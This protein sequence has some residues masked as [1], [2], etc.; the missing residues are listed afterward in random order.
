MS[1]P[2]I[3][4][5]GLGIMGDAMAQALLAG[6]HRVT[7][8]DV[9]AEAKK[10][11]K[12]AGGRLLA[13]AAA[14]GDASDIVIVSLATSKALAATVESLATCKPR[15]DTRAL[16]VLETSTLPL[17]DKNAALAALRKVGI[18]V[19]DCP[20]S[21]TGVRMKERAWTFFCSGA[22]AGYQR[23]EATLRVFTDKI[24]YVGA[25]GNGTKMKYAANHLVAIYNVAYGESVALARKMGLDPQD[26][27]DL[28]ANSPVLGTGV[29]RLRMPFMV[30]RQYT[31]PTMKVEVWQKDMQ[32]I[33]DMAKSVDCPTPLFTAC[34]SIY[35]AAMAQGLDQHDTASV[36][37]V[38]ASMAGIPP[39]NAP[40][41]VVKSAAKKAGKPK[42]A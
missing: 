4:I 22:K 13:S 20:I 29:M 42:K 10:R 18:Q 12:A 2:V 15:A 38:Y 8:Y 41:G 19:L 9:S 40:K 11:F 16:V 23:V 28:F 6:G 26:V 25:F 39:K 21:G 7:G 30:D 17:E 36:A 5:I 3:G 34:A 35:T 33:G 37:E 24:P 32:V 14:V 1:S 27:V 31:P